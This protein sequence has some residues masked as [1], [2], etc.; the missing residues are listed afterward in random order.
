MS[1]YPIL[2]HRNKRFLHITDALSP[3]GVEDAV[4]QGLALTFKDST[5]GISG[6]GVIDSTVRR[7][8]TAT[9]DLKTHAWL[10]ELI[11]KNVHRWNEEHFGYDIHGIERIQFAQYPA[12]ILGHYSAHVDTFPG[13]EIRKLSLSIQLSNPEDYDGGVCELLF[14]DD[15]RIPL[16]SQ[17]GAGLLFPSYFPHRV[18]PVTRGMRY[19]LVA[20]ILGPQ[21]R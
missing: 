8:Q 7:S 13:T 16:K 21:F 10:Y 19:S 4:E 11:A 3:K 17:R 6:S 12:D 15:K 5:V 18:T 2:P 20:W 14:G 1:S 9:Y